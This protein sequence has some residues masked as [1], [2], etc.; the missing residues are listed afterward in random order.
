MQR[1]DTALIERTLYRRAAPVGLGNVLD[2]RQT[3]SRAA[4]LSAAGLVD[5][6]EPLEEP[7]QVLRADPA[8]VVAVPVR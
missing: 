5:P 1:E 4:E 7:R 8:A 6:I 2:D 3:Q